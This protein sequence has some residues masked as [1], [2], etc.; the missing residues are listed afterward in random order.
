MNIGRFYS[1]RQGW[2]EEKNGCG[3]EILNNIN[4]CVK[5]Y[6]SGIIDKLPNID[7]HDKDGKY[8]SNYLKNNNLENE[9]KQLYKDSII[10]FNWYF[11]YNDNINIFSSE[12]L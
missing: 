6:N 12:S 9:Y 11:Y 10:Y 7:L 4:N 3:K 8:I 1:R 5:Y 2:C